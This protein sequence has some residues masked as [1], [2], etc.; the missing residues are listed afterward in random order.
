MAP[1][2]YRSRRSIKV[3]R[4]HSP[5]GSKDSMLGRKVF[6]RTWGGWDLYVF[7]R[8]LKFTRC[9]KGS[10]LEDQIRFIIPVFHSQGPCNRIWTDSPMNPPLSNRP[11]LG[12]RS[13]RR[14]T[15]RTS[16]PPVSTLRIV[17]RKEIVFF[18]YDQ[19]TLLICEGI[20]LFYPLVK[21][22]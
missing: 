19:S 8:I 17:R 22:Y 3:E 10:T 1:L 13:G 4:V 11:S 5:K 6:S 18:C 15:Q 20:H 7:G 16:P 14:R 9:L 12:W 21:R 2:E